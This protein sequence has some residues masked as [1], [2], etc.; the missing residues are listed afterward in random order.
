[1]QPTP[2]LPLEHLDPQTPL[3]SQLVGQWQKLWLLAQSR[4]GHLDQHQQSLREVTQ[5]L[6]PLEIMSYCLLCF[7]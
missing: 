3:L 6:H 4:Q 5:R 7:D 2:P 1:M